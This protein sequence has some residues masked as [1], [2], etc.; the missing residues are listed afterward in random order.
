LTR[1]SRAS[2]RST[3]PTSSASANTSHSCGCRPSLSRVW[4]TGLVEAIIVLLAL[5]PFAFYGKRWMTTLS[6][7]F[8]LVM[9][10]NGL[11][12]IAGAIHFRRIVPGL[13]SSPLLLAG[14]TYLLV[15]THKAQKRAG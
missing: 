1:R 5:S 4:L 11:L 12:H 15:S 8:A 6:F 7:P 10:F 3:T 14:A 13:F 9:L 2:S